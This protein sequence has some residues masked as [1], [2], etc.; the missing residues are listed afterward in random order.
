MFQTALQPYDEAIDSLSRS[1]DMV[2]AT[3]G[4]LH[5]PDP[6]AETAPRHRS[7]IPQEVLRQLNLADIRPEWLTD[8]QL[9][10][11]AISFEHDGNVIDDPEDHTIT[12]KLTLHPEESA[13][14]SERKRGPLSV[15]D[16]S[17]LCPTYF[18]DLVRAQASSRDAGFIPFSDN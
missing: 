1:R 9:H 11:A 13:T 16:T 10:D 8:A 18:R 14:R 5:T 3:L 7:G 17:S 12:G 15:I 2:A 6:G 4:L